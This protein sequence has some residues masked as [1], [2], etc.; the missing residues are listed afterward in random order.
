[1]IDIIDEIKSRTDIVDLIGETVTL[2]K[3]GHSFT[4][5]CPFHTNTHTP[6]F[7]VW[8][9][10]GTWKCFGACNT[11]GDIFSF[12]MKR[13][14]SEFRD[15]LEWLARRAGVELKPVTPE[16]RET[17]RRERDHQAS[18][19]AVMVAGAEFYQAQLWSS[20]GKGARD[21]VSMRGLCDE[22]HI[23]AIRWG[24]SASN[25]ALLKWLTKEHPD[26]IKMAREIGLVRADGKDFTAN[27]EGDTVSPN[28]WLVFP[29]VE[30]GRVTGFSSR[31]L[32]SIE[33]GSKTRHLPNVRGIYRADYDLFDDQR[34]D[35]HPRGQ[36]VGPELHDGHLVI[37]EGPFD[38]ETLRMWGYRAICAKCGQGINEDEQK[39]LVERLR[40][41][42]ERETLYAA[43]SNDSNGAGQ[44]YARKLCELI[45]PLMRV[46]LWPRNKGDSK[47]DANEC[48]QDGMT[49]VELE[50]L[51][52]QSPAHLDMEIERIAKVRDVRA[53]AEGIE[54]LADLVTRLD[55][56][57]RKMYIGSVAEAKLDINKREFEKMVSERMSRNNGSG[58]KIV[59]GELTW[60]GE[61]LI[62]CVA[63][64]ENEQIVDD[65]MNTPLIK[66]HITG[67]LAA[68]A[69][70]PGIDVDASEFDGMKWISKCWGARVF[71][72]VSAGKHHMLRRAIL[73]HSLPTLKREIMY[74]FTGWYTV[75]GKRSFLS[76]AGALSADGLDTQ[77][78]VDLPNNLQHYSLPKP[79]TGDDLNAAV[80]ASLDF[81]SIAPDQITVPLWVAM[82]AAVL[83]P[84]KSLNAVMWVYGPTQSKK[85][86]ISHLALTHFGPG[87]VQGR[88]YKAP[89]DWTSTA[90]DMEATMFTTKD[91]PII[92][93]DYAPQFTSAKEAS[94][95]AKVAHYIVR[96]VGNRSSRG[97]RN[98]DMT[99]KAQFLPRGLVIATAEQP[100]SGQ[101]IVGR[102]ITVPVEV[103][104]VKL[105]RLT[106]A[107]GQHH[108][109]SHAMAAFVQWLAANW[110]KCETQFKAYAFDAQEQ[111]RGV[112]TNQDRLSDY[113]AAL[114][115]S[116]RVALDWM[117]EIGAIDQLEHDNR[118]A[119]NEIALCELLSG[120]SER[121]SAQ[122]PVLKFFEALQDLI[123]Q[124]KL[125]IAP[126]ADINFQQPYGSAL[127][128]WSCTGGDPDHAQNQIY[129]MTAP[130]LSA[131]KEYWQGL[132]E[133]FDTLLDALRREM[134]Q[135][136]YLAERDEHQIE[137][138]KWINNKFGTRRVLVINADLV[139]E[140]HQ[141]DLLN[142]KSVTISANEKVEISF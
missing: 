1:M 130:C 33:H 13:D 69:T 91:A 123:Q 100:L 104:S 87:F 138:S 107:Q 15:A 6:A 44:G 62:N 46:V 88:D 8:P 83:T 27:S 132:D 51:L 95:M 21:Y 120:Q 43:M 76:A 58:V 127:A 45:N 22:K 19:D 17:I 121:I 7:V 90:A 39:A 78:H 10:S 14:N 61:A 106:E 75:G 86:T 49:S 24:F 12:V 92:L 116:S 37:V 134:W 117:L 65:G 29:F 112:F 108:L 133:R 110:E 42:S 81:I 71:P 30:H 99:A 2:K 52:D 50:L 26:M 11:G 101:S 74:T 48:L 103:N 125:V 118:I 18:L 122:S 64:V 60:W 35:E 129:L 36:R 105:D 40:R 20:M 140:R 28:G 80:R 113:Y 73:E 38:A 96:S 94:S 72:Y 5:F 56:T 141:I 85:S 128:G 102:T 139:V 55:V 111:M 124:D 97:R 4:G 34:T 77:A 142:Q 89:K 59:A 47:S 25:D 41:L 57:T 16:E 79:P 54:H 114:A 135:F 31:A 32:S 66:Y 109:Y 84:F 131:V 68:G 136:G 137:P 70:L 23:R 67:K 93:D 98:A 63:Q 9:D 53:R 3:S 126:K 115:A 119:C 82:Y